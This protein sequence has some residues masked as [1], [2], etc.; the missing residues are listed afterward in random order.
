MGGDVSGSSASATV[1]KLQGRT[2][3][4]T[5]PTDLQYLGWN[6][7]ASQWEPKT[8]SA[9]TSV[10]MTGDVS[11]SSGSNTVDKI[12]GASVSGTAPTSGQALVYSGSAWTPT[13]QPYDVPT[14][15]PDKPTS[16]MIM[17]RIIAVRAF[18]LPASLSGSQAT[19]GTAATASTTID[20]Q[21]N[22]VSFGTVVWS[23]AGTTGAF[24]SASGATF[25][26]GDVLRIVAPASADTTLADISITLMGTR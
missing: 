15:T 22:G 12:K 6:N 19:A 26:A 8:I 4:S 7:G 25:A 1:A 18:S 5:G 24:T 13:T 23:A 10:T 14:Y 3:A 11:G 16:S 21:K 9:T 20:L 2:V 17:A